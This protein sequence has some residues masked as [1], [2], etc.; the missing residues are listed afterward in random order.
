MKNNHGRLLVIKPKQIESSRQRGWFEGGL[1]PFIAFYQDNLDHRDV[2]DLEN[3]REWLKME[4]N[5]DYVTINGKTHK[6]AQSTSGVLNEGIIERILN[7]AEDQGMKT[8]VL[9]PA[10]YKKWKNEIY[11]YG[12][13]DNY[14]DYLIK[15]KLLP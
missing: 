10:R 4:F 11:P 7:W 14:I 2:K 1:V 13:P 5:A 12:G 15:I 3:V 6:V 8:E 9:E